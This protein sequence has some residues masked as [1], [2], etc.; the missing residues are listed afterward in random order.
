MILS[1]RVLF[2]SELLDEIDDSIVIRKTDFGVPNES[3]QTAERMG[4]WGSRVTGQ[5]WN[6]LEATVAFAIDIP[7]TEMGRR[8]EVFDKV[9]AWAN[10]KGWLM[11]SRVSDRRM[12]VDKVV[13]PSGGDMRD[14]TDEYTIIFRAYSVPFWESST[15]TT[16]PAKDL[17]SGSVTIDVDGTA[18]GVL[19]VSFRNI[20]G[21][22]ITNFEVSAGGNTLTLNGVNILAGET[23]NITHPTESGGLLKIYSGSRNVYSLRTG[24]DDLVVKPGKVTVTVSAT[25]TGRLTVTNRA[26]WL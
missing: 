4:G 17:T 2:H 15:P 10:Q 16:T 25:R 6:Q 3:V 24:S 14:W 12:Y 1:R 21:K 23:L 9:V 7:K 5:H 19:D 13:I 11:F 18:P 8:R 22:T 20:S 26:R